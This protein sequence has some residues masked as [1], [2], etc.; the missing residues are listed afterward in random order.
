MLEIDINMSKDSVLIVNHDDNFKRFF[1]NPS[2]ISDLTWDQIKQMVSDK[3]GYHPLSFEELA[4]MCSGKVKLMIDVKP[5]NPSA[6][7]YK[8]LGVI[9]EKYH[10]FDGL[11]FIDY[12][13]KKYFWGRAKFYFRTGEAL[14]IKKLIDSGEDVSSNYFLFDHANR[15]NSEV[16][17]WCQLCNIAVVPSVN[18]NH[19]VLENH[20]SGAK[21]DIEFLKECGVTEFQID[22]DYDDYLKSWEQNSANNF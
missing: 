20:L 1:N 17:K 21:R 22:S 8:R 3:G 15:M 19:Y 12:T 5:N 14:E 13:A 4:K 2:K 10:L 9:L 11:Y 7:F 16:V 18:Y 6:G